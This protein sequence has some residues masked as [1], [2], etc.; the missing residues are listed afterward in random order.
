MNKTTRTFATL[1]AAGS[2]LAAPAIALGSPKADSPSKSKSKSGK[3]QSK[4]KG[5]AKTSKV[6][7]SV[8]GTLM[9]FTADDPLTPAN[10]SSVTLKVTSANHHARQSGDITGDTYSVSAATDDAF[11]TKLNGYESPDAPSVGDKV[12]VKGKIA[13]T[14][15]RCAP[16]GT[17]TADRY[18]T[19]ADVSRVTISDRDE[20]VPVAASAS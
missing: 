8:G 4:S 20:D 16:A 18:A 1:A 9:S 17:S 7:F 2:I 3:P 12:K 13:L 19:K 6:G 5:C 11:T 10:E 15:K 14:K